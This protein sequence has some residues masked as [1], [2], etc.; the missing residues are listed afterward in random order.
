M[1]S[2]LLKLS[3]LFVIILTLILTQTAFA[4]TLMPDGYYTQ[5]VVTN[6]VTYVSPTLPVIYKNSIADAASAWNNSSSKRKI[7]FNTGSNY[8]KAISYSDTF[9]GQYVPLESNTNST[10]RTTKFEIHINTRILDNSPPGYIQSVVCHEM[11]HSFG[12]N[13]CNQVFPDTVTFPKIMDQNRDRS[14]IR[15]PQSDDVSGVNTYY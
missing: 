11:G 3:T 5:N 10:N 12:L 13:E 14:M 2:K 6:N 8:I 15:T 1:K 7:S 4:Y 9:Y